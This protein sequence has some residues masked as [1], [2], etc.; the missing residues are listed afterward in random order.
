MLR[1]VPLARHQD[2]FA[3]RL[4]LNPVDPENHLRPA[5][6]GFGRRTL[7]EKDHYRGFLPV[8][9]NP[10]HRQDACATLSNGRSAHRQAQGGE[11]MSEHE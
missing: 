6:A 9:S 11:L 5:N 4:S 7:L 2:R 1:K 8:F 10:E 3:N